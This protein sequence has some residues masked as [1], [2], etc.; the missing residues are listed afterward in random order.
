MRI[1][2]AGKGGAGKTTLSATLARSLARDGKNVLAIDGDP[3]ANLGIALG[4]D[5][6]LLAG[7]ARVPRDLLEQPQGQPAY[8]K[9]A[10]EELR[11]RYAITAPDGV[12]LMA[13]TT[14]EHAGTG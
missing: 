3:N 6:D 7:H 11:A 4:V 10:P 12:Q 2:I 5:G 13:V 8:L 14:V 9:V 1:A